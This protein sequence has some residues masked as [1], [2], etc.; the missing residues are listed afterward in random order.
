MKKWTELKRFSVSRS[1]RSP[2][3]NAVGGARS[4][5]REESDLRRLDTFLRVS[6]RLLCLL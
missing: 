3:G 4:E 5:E 6:E 2:S 1:A